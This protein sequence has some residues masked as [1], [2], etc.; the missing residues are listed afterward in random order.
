MT[1]TIRR[2]GIDAERRGGGRVLLTPRQFEYLQAELGALPPVD[3][4]G[5]I[6]ALVLA[7]LARAPRG[8]MS[9]RAVARRAGVS[10][11]A[12][13]RALRSLR[14]RGLARTRREWIAAGR[15]RATEVIYADATA[16]D[17]PAL[18]PS[19][20][21][22]RF[23]SRTSTAHPTRVPARL[24][25]L[26]WNAD[27]SRIDLERHGAYVAERLVSSGDLDGLAWGLR[28]LTSADWNE[29][30]RNRG[31]SP[32]QRALARNLAGSARP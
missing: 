32:A 26:F 4:L 16:P 21:T 2:L 29:A 10:P 11:T 17:W 19:L 31:L 15:A 9:A 20:A 30:A 13:A 1:R 22:V 3:G 7:A 23:P 24:R 12:A 14:G 18:A 8:L 25:H 27:P 28:A 6:E 5:R